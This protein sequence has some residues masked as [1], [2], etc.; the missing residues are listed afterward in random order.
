MQ[1]ETQSSKK[2]GM[3]TAT[4]ARH[5]DT[6]LKWMHILSEEVSRQASME[7]ELDIKSSLMAAPKKD[8]LSMAN[9]QLG[10]MNMFAIPLFQGVADILPAMN[11]TVEELE[12]NKGL[13]EQKVLQEKA[14]QNLDVADATRQ[15]RE[16]TLSPRT[17]SFIE[18]QN[19]E[20]KPTETTWSQS[21][22]DDTRAEEQNESVNGTPQTVLELSPAESAEHQPASPQNLSA[23]STLNEPAQLNSK[24]SFYLNG[25]LS[26]FDAV[27]ELAHSDPFNCRI[28]GDSSADK[29]STSAGQRCSE[30]TDGSLS[31]AFGGDW[32]SQATSAATGKHALSPS[33]Q[34]TSI[35]SNDSI[36]RTVGVSTLS[37]SPPGAKSLGAPVQLE[38]STSE[39]YYG[40][41]TGSIGKAE[42][43]TLK[44]RPSRFRMKDFPFFRRN[45]G[46]SSPPFSASDPAG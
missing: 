38:P 40:S 27:R 8:M 25:S 42:G 41:P 13:F 35:V 10:F 20:A 43:K 39:E 18:E 14:K 26:S 4:Q 28:R 36:D 9:A 37:A 21:Q 32:A 34:G 6:A 2:P 1:N 3:L 33:T 7:S 16:G 12:I 17:R 23:H 45:K 44:K 22:I 30:T 11:Y 15:L 46:S 19:A 31:G 29:T 5:H 24:D